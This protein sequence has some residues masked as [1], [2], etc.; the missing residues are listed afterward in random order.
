[1][2]KAL[3]IIVFVLYGL[4]LITYYSDGFVW[5]FNMEREVDQLTFFVLV[6]SGL[7]ALIPANIAK[8]KGR[9]FIYWYAYGIALWIFAMIHSIVI[10]PSEESFLS[11]DDKYKKCPFCAEIIKKEAIVCKHCNRDLNDK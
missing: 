2:Y 7:I 1:M 5:H 3:S 6:F 4:G 9:K 10:K 11:N 8:N